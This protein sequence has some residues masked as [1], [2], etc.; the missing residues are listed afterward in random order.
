L[1]RSKVNF[2]QWTVSAKPV[3]HLPNGRRVFLMRMNHTSAGER[4]LNREESVGEPWSVSSRVLTPL[5]TRLAQ[6]RTL[7]RCG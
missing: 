2:K 5:L 6:N 4:S 7:A 3:A 1:Y